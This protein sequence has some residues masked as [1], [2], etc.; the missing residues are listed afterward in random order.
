MNAIT[1]MYHDIV[2]RAEE[3]GFAGADAAR[4]K[5][6]PSKFDAHLQAIAEIPNRKPL[7]VTDWGVDDAPIFITFDDGGGSAIHAAEMLEKYGWR[8]HFF[9][10]TGKIGTESFVTK[11]EIRELNKRGHIVG[12]HSE[13]HPLR[14]ASLC[15]DE[16]FRE[17]RISTEKLAEIISE[18][19]R[20]ASV[21]GGMYSRVV[22]ECAES[23]GIEF[24]FNSEPTMKVNIV[25][26]CQIL[27]RYV[28]KNRME[29]DEISSIAAGKIVPRLKQSLIWNAKK[30]LK[31]IGG[32]TFL[33]FRKFL[34]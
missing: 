23:N 34:N 16:V 24:L 11:N 14:M 31:K 27:G 32:D 7:R 4:Y 28:V 3:S 30:P 17:W 10:T 20:V 18:K 15:R 12:S 26:S 5:I 33:R 1:L 19:V 8:G 13:S 21:P 2:D 22:A 25:G 9:I 29:A 6:L